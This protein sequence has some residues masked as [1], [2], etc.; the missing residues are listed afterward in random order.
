MLSGVDG[1]SSDGELK[2]GGDSTKEN[3]SPAKKK[4]TKTTEIALPNAPKDGKILTLHDKNVHSS[5][6]S[7]LFA[8]V[9]PMNPKAGNKD[10][11]DVNK[12]PSAR[13]KAKDKKK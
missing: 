11:S 12:R 6:V 3:A 7:C 1:P 5:N 9:H 10:K 4:R 2:R 13:Q 8:E